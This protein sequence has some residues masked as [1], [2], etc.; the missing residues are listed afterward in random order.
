MR[1]EHTRCIFT[2]RVLLEESDGEIL[3]SEY[4]QCA[5]EQNHSGDHLIIVPK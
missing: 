4:I 1:L 3:N 2:V 5:N